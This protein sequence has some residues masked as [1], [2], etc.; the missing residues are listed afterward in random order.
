MKGFRKLLPAK[1]HDR[2]IKEKP[3]IKGI[4]YF[5]QLNVSHLKHLSDE[6]IQKAFMD[7]Y[8]LWKAGKV[9]T[10]FPFGLRP[11]KS[12][13]YNLVMNGLLDTII[14]RMVGTATSSQ[15]LQGR[16]LAIGTGNVTPDVDE[17]VL[18]QEF[19]R[20]SFTQA[21]PVDNQASFVLFVNR[22]TAN[23]Y[24]TDAVTDAGNTTTYFLVDPA[25]A[26]NFQI[27]NTI[28]V[29]TSVGF[30]FTTVT[31]INL[32]LN[33]LTVNPPLSAIP[34]TGDQVVQAWAEA[35]VFGNDTAT[36]VANTGT[37]FNRVNQLDFA[38]DDQNVILI[39]VLFIF[40]IVP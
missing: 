22:S 4:W 12:K 16:K 8:D 32:A 17:T 10:K 26:A 9:A 15:D 30:D 34:I 40:T 6:E 11:K 19:Y 33:T 25:T 35:G 29:T 14:A 38:K 1:R 7:H 20:A 36:G 2:S 5:D 23:G 28:R 31:D 13:K 18:E 39:E 24:T 21:T 27:G 37:M 3:A